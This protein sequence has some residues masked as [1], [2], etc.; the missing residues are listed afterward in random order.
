MKILFEYAKDYLR[1]ILAGI[2]F[3]AIYNVYSAVLR[4]KGNSRVP[5]IA[6]L[7]SSIINALLDFMFIVFFD[8][9]TA[10][11]ALEINFFTPLPYFM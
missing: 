5:F 8:F 11:A 7:I 4:G 6:V 3:L 2:P 10:G 9:G 1:I